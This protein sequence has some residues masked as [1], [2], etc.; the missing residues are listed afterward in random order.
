MTHIWPKCH[1]NVPVEFKTLKALL[2]VYMSKFSFKLCSPNLAGIWPTYGHATGQDHF[3]S[4]IHVLCSP[5]RWCTA[6]STYLQNRRQRRQ[7]RPRN[8]AT[9]R[10]PNITRTS[11][12]NVGPC[13]PNHSTTSC[14]LNPGPVVVH[15]C[16][17]SQWTRSMKPQSNVNKLLLWI[18]L[19]KA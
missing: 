17:P 5:P 10:P 11:P 13:Y 7:R 1:Q 8:P 6:T 14:R 15:N 9:L 19:L 18:S 16:F 4:Q 3:S 2:S 12:S